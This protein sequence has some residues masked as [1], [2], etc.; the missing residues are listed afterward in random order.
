MKS[1]ALSIGFSPCPNDTFIFDALLHGKI[2]TEG[3]EF[4]PQLEDVETLNRMAGEEKLDITKLSFFALYHLREKYTL[5]PSGSA[6]G[7]GVGPLL[8]SKKKYSDISAIRSVAIP[9]KHTTAY[10]LFR[11]FFPELTNTKEIIFSEIENAVLNE[12][13]DAGLIIHE[14]R[15]TYADKG[16]IKIADLGELW[17]KETGKPIPLGGIAIRNSLP[18]EL[19]RKVG[20]LIKA[21]VE[22]AFRFPESSVEYVKM[23]A[24]AMDPSVRQKHIDLYVNKYS[25][26]LGK[27]GYEAVEYMFKKAKELADR[28]E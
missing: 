7:R 14:N 24:Q 5:L 28:P 27:D 20:S 11:T 2:N 15:F 17:E 8:I 23:H 1:K 13:V 9:G 16:L 19:K 4:L 3:L 22:F 26:D 6:L 12:E 21:S 10:F 18:E 25:I